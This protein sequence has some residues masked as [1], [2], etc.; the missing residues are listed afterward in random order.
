LQV[1][2]STLCLRREFV[3]YDATA[4][5]IAVHASDDPYKR[6]RPS[7]N[8]RH[9]KRRSVIVIALCRRTK[10]TAHIRDMRM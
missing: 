4:W 1:E 10:D 6:A 2:I 9:V 8:S 5:F 7:G 3:D